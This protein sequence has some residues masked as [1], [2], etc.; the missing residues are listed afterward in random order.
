MLSLFKPLIDISSLF[1]LELLTLCA[2]EK[3]PPLLVRVTLTG[4]VPVGIGVTPV[5]PSIIK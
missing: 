4:T 5:I 1:A 3:L 2:P